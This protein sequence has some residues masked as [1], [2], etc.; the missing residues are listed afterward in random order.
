MKIRVAIDVDGTVQQVGVLYHEARGARE[1]SLF[2]YL[3]QWSRS[4]GF[5][6]APSMPLDIPL[7][8]SKS[9]GAAHESALPGPI[10][11]AAPDAWDRRVIE[12][13]LE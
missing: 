4:G 8:T 3:P 13:K 5:A 7:P 10:A 6:L 2:E 1:T 11:D 12:H 9:A